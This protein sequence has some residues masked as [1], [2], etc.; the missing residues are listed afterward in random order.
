MRAA[1]RRA[2]V[3]AMR[4]DDLA[5]L[6]A[7]A[8]IYGY[9]LVF[10]LGEVARIARHG[11]GDVPPTPLNAFGHARRLAGPDEEFVSINNDTLYSIASID[12]GGGPVRLDVPDSAGRYYVMQFVDAWTNNFAYVGHRATGT[13]AGSFLLVPPGW[14]GDAPGDASVIRL[15]TAVASIVGRWAV[16]GDDDLPAVHAL[17]DALAL[18][19]TGP[20]AGLPVPGRGVPDDLAFFEELR[21]L[22]RAFPPA[23]RD[24]AYQERFA[25]LGLLDGESPYPMPG[26]TLH[27]ALTEGLAAGRA[28]LEDAV[29]G[30]GSATQNGWGLTYHAFDYNLDFF[31]VGALDDP[32]WT[33]PDGPARYVQRAAAARGGLWGNHGYEAA[34]AMVYRDGA[35]EPLDGSR[36]YELR[37]AEEPPCAAFWSVTMYDAQDFFLVPNPIDRYSVGDR[38]RGL[39][40]GADG[41]LTIVLQRDE[42]DSAAGR[43]NWLPTPA[44]AFRPILRMYEP[45][46][47]VF[48]GRYELPPIVRV[49]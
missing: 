3:A 11:L 13:A 46:D 19:P 10:D 32:R 2:S 49:G 4:D 27:A 34:Y 41:S 28:L 20:G 23:G 31:E 18:T 9:P 29:K 44:G 21:V 35:G 30:G 47:A 39:E 36:R 45:D 25:P 1:R 40:R 26:P 8:F 14:E 6:A 22:M 12:A 37:F 48:D 42:P 7:E 16:D 15:P 24:R 17:Q 38:T 43:A 5:T 33:L